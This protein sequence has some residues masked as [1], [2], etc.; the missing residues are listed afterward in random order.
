[1]LAVNYG[2][3][4][5][6]TSQFLETVA[7][8]LKRGNVGWSAPALL[9]ESGAGFT[10]YAAA[11]VVLFAPFIACLALLR[12][13]NNERDFSLLAILC[14]MIYP[15][16][17]TYDLAATMAPLLVVIA[18][19]SNSWIRCSL[20][21]LLLLVSFY[22]FGSNSNII[23]QWW[24]FIYLALTVGFADRCLGPLSM[25]LRPIQAS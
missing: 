17:L 21:V 5:D 1:L 7:E 16:P 18:A 13:E 3:H 19:S 6:Q 9:L 14:L 8:F 15:R 12:F 20:Y 4:S 23:F 2:I 10:V 22:N 24:L 25:R 11:C